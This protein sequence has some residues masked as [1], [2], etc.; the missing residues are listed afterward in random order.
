MTR[1]GNTPRM[2]GEGGDRP[3]N[4]A[5]R[6]I[7]RLGVA[8]VTAALGSGAAALVALEPQNQAPPSAPPPPDATGVVDPAAMPAETWCEPWVWRP[9]DWAGQAL[10]L[11][12]VERNEPEKAPSL[13]QTFPGQF[14]F[15]GISPAP[16][17]RVRADGAIRIR[18]RNLLGADFGKMWVGPCP[19]PLSLPPEV[20]F[21]FECQVAKIA[22]KP[23]PEKPDP[24]FNITDHIEALGQYLSVAMMDGHCMTGVSN[25]EH[26]SRVTNLHAHGLHIAPHVNAGR[27]TASDDVFLRLMSRDDWARRQQLS[28]GACTPAAHEHVG[29]V[30]Y[31][32]VLGHVQRAATQRAGKRPQADPP[33][34]HWYHPHAHGSTHDQVSSGMAGFLIV[35]GDVDD[36]I[37]LA[38]T[39]SAHPDPTEPTGPHDYRERLVFIQRV[40]VPSSDFNAPGSRRQ[41]FTSAPVPPEG[42]PPPTV[43]FMRPGAV[44]RWRV[45]N[46]SVDGRGFKRIMVL[47]G[48]FV[49]KGD[50]L[51]RVEKGEGDAPAR[52]LVA[53]TRAGIEAA[54]LPLYQLA[55]DGLTLVTLDGGRARHTIK[56]LSTQNAGTVNPFTRPPAAGESDME[57][58]LRNI[59][60]CFRDGESLRH[61]FIRP[62][63]VWL[64]T[65][66]RTDLFFKT[67]LDSAGRIFTLLAQEEVLHT[68]NFQGRLQRG[69][70]TGRAFGPGNPG[71]VDLVVAHVHV[72][73]TPVAGG[74]FDVL[75][76]RDRL[77]PVPPFLQPIADDETR[78]PAVEARARGVAAGSHRTRVVSYTGYGSAGF[79]IIEVPE[80]Y[81]KAHPELRN[82]TWAEHDGTRVLLAPN[83]RTMAINHRMDLARSAQP[84]LPQKFSAGH[85]DR[86]RTLV[87]TAEEWVL[88]NPSLT[89][90]AHTDLDR[91]PQRGSLPGQ[92]PVRTRRPRGWAGAVL[93]ELGV[94][95]RHQ[96][97]RSPVPHP[98]QPDVGHA[99]RGA[100]RAG[101]AAQPARRAAV[102]GHGLDPPQ[103]RPRRLPHAVRGLHGPLDPPLPHSHARGHGHD[104]GGRVRGRGRVFQR[105]PARPGR[106]P[107]HDGRGGQRDLPE[108]VDRDRVP[109]GA[110]VRGPESRHRA[111]LSRIRARGARARGVMRAGRGR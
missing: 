82:L 63:E 92:Y 35:E 28:G 80:F 10:D 68:D 32:F 45:L 20:A 86:I 56:D 9:A 6:Q 30:D 29:Y 7:L 1:S 97:R 49:Y 5:R 42:I 14:S 107:R 79:P 84:P 3:S 88:Y 71:P 66:N 4:P 52:R 43:M 93:E 104:A 12:V 62:N 69:I 18:L 21:A 33:G 81:A 38:M 75:S 15:G 13:G 111:G 23:C 108:A 40:I 37:N 74:A 98:H 48:Q 59:E 101:P 17:I 105:P 76:L 90:W 99:H 44:E 95:D 57:A 109:P 61:T 50:R 41:R 87:D 51:Y 11:N 89:L 67:P 64:A 39:G 58:A 2:G 31:E 83:A 70:T 85:P 91:F 22:G 19:D 94:P 25:S 65:A 16:T 102:D 96:R 110:V 77:P 26:G 53:M 34:T 73:G 36:A 47:D 106:E 55:F 60:A 27:G 78:M 103:R 54:K 46:A 100:G 8:G 24:A 72:R